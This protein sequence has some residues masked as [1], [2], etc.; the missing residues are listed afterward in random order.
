[1]IGQK[2]GAG[3]TPGK[4]KPLAVGLELYDLETDLG[5][6]KNLAAERPE[7]V[8]DLQSRADSMREQLGDSLRKKSGSAVRKA[9]VAPD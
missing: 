7:V 9:G 5:E 3:G 4:Y 6:T 2:P 8:Q 1:M